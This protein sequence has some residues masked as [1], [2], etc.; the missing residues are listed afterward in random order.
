LTLDE[1]LGTIEAP[2]RSCGERHRPQ[3]ADPASGTLPTTWEADPGTHGGPSS[4][5]WSPRLGVAAGLSGAAPPLTLS[6]EVHSTEL[7]TVPPSAFLQET[8]GGWSRT[9]P[10]YLA[11]CPDLRNAR[12]TRGQKVLL[13]QLRALTFVE[14]AATAARGDRPRGQALG[15]PVE[16][17]CKPTR[18]GTGPWWPRPQDR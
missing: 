15:E 11:T 10:C 6:A 5:C 8:R 14:Q 4:Q 2:S 7:V 1:S 9:P 18:P 16:G 12:V 3:Q 13:V 17:Q